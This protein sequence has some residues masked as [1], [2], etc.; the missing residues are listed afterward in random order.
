MLYQVIEG[1]VV[2]ME[3]LEPPCREALDPKSSASTNF[4][5]SASSGWRLPPIPDNYRD[6]TPH[7]HSKLE[8]QM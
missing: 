2:R 8:R 7:P 6:G 3:G 4:A 1:F 5:T